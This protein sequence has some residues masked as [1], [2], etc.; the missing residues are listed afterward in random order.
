MQSQSQPLVLTIARYPGRAT[1]HYTSCK[2]DVTS[3][4]K[5]AESLLRLWLLAYD[6]VCMYSWRNSRK[7]WYL[8][9]ATSAILLATLALVLM[10]YRSV[11]RT[12]AQAALSRRRR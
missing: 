7:H 12:E 6:A 1:Y 8:V 5:C 10:Q 2:K 9:A 11:R 3:C 4:N